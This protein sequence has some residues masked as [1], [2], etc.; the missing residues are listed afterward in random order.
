MNNAYSIFRSRTFWTLVVAG[1]LPIVNLFTPFLPP[2]YQA[3]AEVVLLAV[4]NAFH[5]D[6][7]KRA[8][9]VN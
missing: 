4:A 8:G 5:L 9:A 7:A 6:T 1:A 2:A 3:L